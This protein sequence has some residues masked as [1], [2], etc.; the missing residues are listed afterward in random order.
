MES[1]EQGSK[2][3]VGYAL[4]AYTLWG[5]APIY[6]KLTE[7]IPADEV[8]SARV[9]WTLVTMLG[10]LLLTGRGSEI[11]PLLRPGRQ[12]WISLA[13]ALLLSLNWLT[14]I[15]AV[16][17]DRVTATSLGYYI[18]PLVSV[19][20]GLV[21]LRERLRARQ[22]LAVTLALVGVAS[23]L[24]NTGTLPWIS[25]VLA[26]SFAF[27]GLIHKLFPSPPRAGLALEMTLLA[28]LA[29][30]YA[31]WLVARGD[32]AQMDAPLTTHLLLAASGL[33]SAAPLLCFHAATRRLPLVSVGMFQYLAPTIA[34]L[35]AVFVFG[36]PFE[37]ADALAFGCVWAGL[38]CF[39]WD[40]LIA[41]RPGLRHAP[42]LP[43]RH[44]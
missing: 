35:L 3:G 12:L 21:I 6:W 5:F 27:Y 18:N 40:S 32:S 19:L 37:R 22:A 44:R 7:R 38:A 10:L 23:L 1:G 13:A 39:V 43:S 28:P 42:P 8:I 2:T 17:T 24:L 41:L 16:H 14:F 34:L 25:L 11:R 31:L 30:G 15:Y 20:L 33:V 29:T 26:V 9:L 4:G 36:E